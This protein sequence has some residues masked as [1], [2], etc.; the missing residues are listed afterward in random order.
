MDMKRQTGLNRNNVIKPISVENSKDH[1]S[2]YFSGESV[3]DGYTNDAG[4]TVDAYAIG[5]PSLVAYDDFENENLVRG[6]IFSEVLGPPL[7]RRKR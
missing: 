1:M 5:T 2:D 7:S 6:I 3:N 4:N